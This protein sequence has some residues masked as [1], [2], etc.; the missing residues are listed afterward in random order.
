MAHAGQRH[1][2]RIT[3]TS[4]H[5]GAEDPFRDGHVAQE[6]PGFKEDAPALQ[7]H[8]DQ[9]SRKGQIQT[10]EK[11]ILTYTNKGTQKFFLK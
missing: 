10:Q 3:L 9:A 5:A 7:S 8:Q 11:L 4:A 2:F 6:A 1:S